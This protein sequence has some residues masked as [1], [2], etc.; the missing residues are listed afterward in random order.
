MD[1]AAGVTGPSNGQRAP[2]RTS[3]TADLIKIHDTEII[4]P[5]TMSHPLAEIHH[6]ITFLKSFCEAELFNQIVAEMEILMVI[7]KGN[8]TL[9]D[10]NKLVTAL[11]AD[12]EIE[13]ERNRMLETLTGMSMDRFNINGATHVVA[14]MTSPPDHTEG[15]KGLTW[16]SDKDLAKTFAVRFA[17]IMGKRLTRN[18]KI[19]FQAKNYASWV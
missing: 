2:Q 7:Q 18:L 4:R 11:K 9:K 14:K 10:S 16:A 15:Y 19:R 3:L 8:T 12:H 6:I 17:F 1:M 5:I 13:Y